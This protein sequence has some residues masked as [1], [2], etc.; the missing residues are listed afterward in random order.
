MPPSSNF[1]DELQ[2]I[3]QS[4]PLAPSQ[5]A[6]STLHLCTDTPC[7]SK[8]LQPGWKQSSVTATITQPNQR[9]AYSLK[10]AARGPF[11]VQVTV[12]ES[13]MQPF[14]KDG[15]EWVREWRISNLRPQLQADNPAVKVK[16]VSQVDAWSW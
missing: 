9:H 5:A 11:R 15:E 12:H 2:I 4:L 14:T 7:S 13:Y 16:L 1:D 8:G 10:T 3:A 6:N